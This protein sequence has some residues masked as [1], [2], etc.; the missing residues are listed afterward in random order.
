MAITPKQLVLL[1]VTETIAR[2]SA[3]PK[4]AT[5]KLR[6]VQFGVLKMA[7][8]MNAITA[9]EFTTADDYIRTAAAWRGMRNFQH[10]EEWLAEYETAQKKFNEVWL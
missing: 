10:V 4:N 1:D 8:M 6:D 2:I 3:S 9:E 7:R 5:G